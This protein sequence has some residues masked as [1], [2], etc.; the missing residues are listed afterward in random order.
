MQ[1]MNRLVLEDVLEE[2]AAGTGVIDPA[3]TGTR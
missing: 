3:D 2:V 1:P